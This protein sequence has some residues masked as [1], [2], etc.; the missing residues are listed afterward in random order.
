M[1]A[2]TGAVFRCVATGTG[3]TATSNSASLFFDTVASEYIAAVIAAGG[4]ISSAKQIKVK[5]LVLALN[6][7]GLLTKIKAMYLFHGG[8]QASA[9]LNLMNPTTVVGSF[10]GTFIGT[11]TLQVDGG[12]TPSSGNYMRS[13]FNPDGGGLTDMSGAGIGFY[14][15]NNTPASEYTIGLYNNFWMAPKQGVSYLALSNNYVNMGA[16]ENLSGFHFGTREPGTSQ[17]RK[18]RNGTNVYSA[19]LAF[20]SSY[21]TSNSASAVAIVGGMLEVPSTVYP[22][23][24]PIT[25]AFF[26][27]GMTAAE[28]TTLNT[29]IQEYVA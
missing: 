14:G 27:K 9:K 10:C 23:T 12:M 21:A 4:T 24:L 17:L 26:S 3:G 16:S 13:G 8:V 11:P 1:A 5:A 20:S 7:S 6:N 25:L 28:V 18:Y 29:I 22:S 19:T 15:Q 2:D